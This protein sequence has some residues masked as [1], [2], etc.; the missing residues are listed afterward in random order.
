MTLLPQWVRNLVLP[1]YERRVMRGLDRLPRPR[2]VGIMLDGNRRWARAAGH[3]D[4]SEGY[5]RGG[6]KVQEFLTWCEK[7]D[8]GHVSLFMLSDDNMGRPENE[9]VP[10]LRIIEDTVADLAAPRRP[11]Q[12]S[13]IGSLDLLPAE[14]AA[15]LKEA[16]TTSTSPT[17]FAWAP[18]T[19]PGNRR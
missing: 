7:A 16:T 13:V 5:R 9:L 10:L 19:T 12:V 17:T 6:A 2:H 15:A 8:V 3:D 1:V 11:W 4:V 18:S 14:H